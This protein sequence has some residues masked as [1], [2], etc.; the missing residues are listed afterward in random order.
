[1]LGDKARQRVLDKY[2]LQGNVTKLETL[3]QKLCNY[4]VHYSST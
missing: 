1:M 3:Y 4:Q 2:T